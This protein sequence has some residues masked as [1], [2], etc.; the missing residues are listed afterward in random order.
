VSS[1]DPNAERWRNPVVHRGWQ[2]LTRVASTTIAF[3][4]ITLLVFVAFYAA[5]SRQ[6]RRARPQGT[7]DRSIHGYGHYLWR[8]FHGDLGHSIYYREAVTTR[9]FH[10]VPVTLSLLAGGLVIG[11]LFGLVP[12][13]H[14]RGW[15]DRGLALF[16]LAGVCIHPVWASLILSWLLGGHWHLLPPQGYCG[17]TTLSTGCNG[18]PHWASHLLLPW[19]VLGVA[20]GAYYSVAV[21]ELVR[22]ELDQEYVR[23]ARAKGVAER[24][25]VR[26]HVLRNIS[27]QLLALSVS[28]LGVLFSA[29]VFVETIFDL[30]GIGSIFRRSLLQH[31][32][33]VTAGIVLLVTL[34]ILA[35][36]FVADL[37]TLA[38][39][40][41]PN[42][43]R[44]AAALRDRRALRSARTSS[45][46]A[47]A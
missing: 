40:P 9:V 7:T 11:M 18:A 45:S 14:P 3:F 42:R 46:S 28:N 12:L 34:T 16:A 32:L 33:P 22:V 39:E 36:S 4:A 30:P 20:S 43:Q 27:G 47:R 24:R 35:L 38:L 5:P 2:A 25:I 37:A 19:I 6:F 23:T 31:D 10:A 8:L 13:L 29:A 44:R 15:I 17:V 41:R 21:R 1:L 26:T